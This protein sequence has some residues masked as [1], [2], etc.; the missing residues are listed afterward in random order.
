MYRLMYVATKEGDK[1]REGDK[2]AGNRG[3]ATYQ[4]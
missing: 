1:T 2:G 4:L 3:T